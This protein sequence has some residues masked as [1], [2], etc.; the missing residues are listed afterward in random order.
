MINA[1]I[2]DHYDPSISHGLDTYITELTRSI[3]KTNNRIH[4]SYI[5]IHETKNT[6]FRKEVKSRI[7]HY[8]ISG[9]ITNPT[10]ETKAIEWLTRCFLVAISTAQKIKFAIKDFFSRCDQISIH[11]SCSVAFCRVCYITY[12]A[13]ILVLQA[14][15]VYV[16]YAPTF[17]TYSRALRACVL[18]FLCFLP[19]F[20][21]LR[22]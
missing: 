9:N 8:H 2:I 5:W 21:S 6:G 22:P 11:F 1:Y 13:Y 12:L 14:S 3:L 16:P 19:A 15:C 17:L 7:S 20:L 4:L 10:F 18:L